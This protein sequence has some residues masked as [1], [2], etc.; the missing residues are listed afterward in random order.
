MASTSNDEQGFRLSVHPDP[1]ATGAA[2]A[3]RA[4]TVIRAAIRSRGRARV[5]FA[6]APSQEEFLKHLGA[7]PEIDWARVQGFHMDEYIG[8]SPD[9]PQAFARWL[10]ERLPA[11]QFEPI[12]PGADP[13][14][15]AL[16]YATLVTA[17]P[18]DLTCLG[19]GVNG[20]IAFN[21]PGQCHFD[22]PHKVRLITLDA[23]S[24]QQQVDDECFDRL[25]DVPR[26]ALT[27]TVP[28]LLAASSI[29]GVVPGQHKAPAVA[30]MVADPIGPD[31]P[32]TALR[33]HRDAAMFLDD[34]A[35]SLL[36]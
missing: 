2:A 32:A 28:A 24:R 22:D 33:T 9:A 13:N 20:H 4:G 34:A 31:C 7:E 27:L 11:V 18:I 35:A 6:A 25:D 1:A 10:T 36:K 15:E 29:V 23:A 30:R 17:D 3:G 8:L 16:R 5:V 19:I 14:A 21:E 26:S 12:T